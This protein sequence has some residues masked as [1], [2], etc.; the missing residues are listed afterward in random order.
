[1]SASEYPIVKNFL[2]FKE[3]G[4]DCI[5]VDYRAG[6]IDPK[7]RKAVKHNLVTEVYPFLAGNPNIWKRINILLEGVKKSNI[8]KLYSPEKII[9]EEDH[10]Y[11]VY[12]LIKGKSFEVVL[13][14]SFQKDNPI[15]FDLAFSIA[16]SIADLIDVG[17]SI[18]VSGE[19][20]FHGFLTPDNIIIDYDGKIY[21][22]IMESIPTSVRKR[23]FLTRSLKSTAPGSPRSS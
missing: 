17:S 10:S 20:S 4:T 11:L 1:M 9:H 2:F 15:N 19:K 5:G 18:V 6:E 23:I 12:P 16:L 7:T 22:K 13:D 21:L 8:P 3:T 14:D